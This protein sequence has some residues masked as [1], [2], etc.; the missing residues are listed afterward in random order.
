MGDNGIIYKCNE[1]GRL[2]D[3]PNHY[4]ETH[5]LDTPPYEEIFACP[6]CDSFSYEETDVCDV[7]GKTDY[8]HRFVRS[9]QRTVC[10]E[11]WDDYADE[12]IVHMNPLNACFED[13]RRR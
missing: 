13:G 8:A 7:C 4:F 3:T 1:C 5:G 10:M 12:D 2:F 11:C 9:G 6:Y